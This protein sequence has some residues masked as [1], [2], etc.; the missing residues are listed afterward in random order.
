MMLDGS[1]GRSAIEGH[2]AFERKS[3]AKAAVAPGPILA[4]TG[5]KSWNGL[6]EIG[7]M[8]AKNKIDELH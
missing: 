8:E 1:P 6:A 2:Q 3:L 4:I 5:G 7:S